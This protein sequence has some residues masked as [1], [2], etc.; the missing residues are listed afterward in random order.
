VCVLIGS[1]IFRHPAKKVIVEVLHS[2][3]Y[4]VTVISADR[5]EKSGEVKT[6]FGNL[7]RLRSILVKMPIVDIPILYLI[8][9][10]KQ[11]YAF[12]FVYAP[13]PIIAAF[14][15]KKLGKK[16]IYWIGDD[17]ASLFSEN[18]GILYPK[19]KFMTKFFHDAYR[20]V[21]KQICNN[22]NAVITLTKSLE[23]DR[24]D[25]KTKI[26][27][28]YRGISH[29]YF[30]NNDQNSLPKELLNKKLIAYVGEISILRGLK[31][32]LE[33]FS[34]VAKEI[35]DSILL[36]VGDFNRKFTSQADKSYFEQFIKS[37]ELEGRVFITGWVSENKI[38]EYL[39]K[40][41]VGLILI[42]PWCYSYQ[43]SIPDKLI[44][45]LMCGL[46]V[47]ASDELS[48]VKNIIARV[49]CGITASV[50]DLESI[51]KSIISLLKNDDL[52]NM[53]SKNAINYAHSNH[54][55]EK[56]KSELEVVI[57]YVINN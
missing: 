11:N 22:F 24:L 41:H 3:G 29:D 12:Y 42:E 47:V 7:I 44:D 55:F 27:S 57:H 34:Y 51:S 15:L 6:D 8:K 52:R 40:S 53:M 1:S 25:F 50:Y 37:K 38:P 28:L 56:Y 35:P 32:T 13:H 54:S 21:E 45:M 46:P 18:F 14:F 48:E 31:N 23:E 16:V 49:E 17:N 43:I 5:S 10:L 4:S 9:A 33:S 26:F 36:M 2:L 30:Q 39:S 20:F 19:I